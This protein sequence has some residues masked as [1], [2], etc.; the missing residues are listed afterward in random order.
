MWY[1]MSSLPAPG[2]GGLACWAGWTPPAP[3]VGVGGA[4]PALHRPWP[5]GAPAMTCEGPPVGGR[6]VPDK[7]SSCP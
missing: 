5:W 1:H 2:S 4:L 3:P 7:A 6:N